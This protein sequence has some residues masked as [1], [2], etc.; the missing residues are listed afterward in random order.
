MRNTL[1]AKRGVVVLLVMAFLL[2]G[3]CWGRVAYIALIKG[4]EYKTKAE[5]QQLSVTTVNA[6]RGTIYD[7]NMNVLAQSA[8]VWLE[9]QIL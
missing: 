7:R 8:A 9:E 4:D 1:M 5:T 2:I 6:T 3:V